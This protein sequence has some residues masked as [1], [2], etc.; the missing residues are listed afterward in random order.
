MLEILPVSL[1]QHLD[2]TR[3][4]TCPCVSHAEEISIQV[5]GPKFATRIHACTKF[6]IQ[7]PHQKMSAQIS[8]QFLDNQQE[9]FRMQGIIQ[10]ACQ[11]QVANSAQ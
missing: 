2:T 4:L 6:S 10:C 9:N 1:S 3:I 11:T 7:N 8:S 5:S